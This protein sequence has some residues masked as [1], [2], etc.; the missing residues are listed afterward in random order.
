MATVNGEYK[1]IFGWETDA[2]SKEYREFLEAFIP[3]FIA[4]MKSK[5]NADKRCWFH[6]SDEPKMEHMEQYRASYNMLKGLLKDYPIIDALSDYD[7][8]K[9]EIIERPVSAND[10]IKPFLDNN[11]PDL[12]TYYCCVQTK[13]VS[14]RFISMPSAR[15]RVIGLQMYK[16]NIV[17]FL[18]WGYNFYNTQH[19]YKLLNP[20]TRT[21]SENF[22]PSGDPFVV[23]PAPDGTPYK[24]LRLLV[25]EEALQDMRALK[26]CEKLCGREKVMEILEDGI[27]P[28]T[29]DKYPH[30]A[31]WLLS[32]RE[33]INLEI[34]N[35]K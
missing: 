21:D 23:Y 2:C 20:F 24:S 6:V 30:S 29:F 19:S 8:Y 18:Q 31:E 35:R 13:G 10:H 28:I 25:F 12:W 34:M 15:N 22:V 4:F 33:R 14:N 5:H 3:E 16:F 11:V 1:K 17:G 32:V 27:T 26:L 9:E 7:F